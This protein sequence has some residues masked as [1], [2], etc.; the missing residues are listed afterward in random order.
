MHPVIHHLHLQHPPIHQHT[1]CVLTK[2]VYALPPSPP[3]PPP[4]NLQAGKQL[5]WL[6]GGRVKAGMHEVRQGLIDGG[7]GA[8]CVFGVVCGVG[9][10]K[11]GMHDVGTL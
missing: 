10:S 5:E 6:T 9:P 1:N 11:A 8:A 2:H 7:G 4:I 3:P